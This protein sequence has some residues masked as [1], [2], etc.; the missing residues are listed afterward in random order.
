MTRVVS[1]LNNIFPL[2][3]ETQTLS[4]QV[5]QYAILNVMM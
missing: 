4:S 2:H 5:S 3:Y 1:M